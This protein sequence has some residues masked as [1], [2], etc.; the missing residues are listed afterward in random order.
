MREE[1]LQRLLAEVVRWVVIPADIADR[2]AS[3]LRE[4]QRDKEREHRAALMRLQQRHLAV[5]AKL[6][7][8]Y[9]DRPRP[10]G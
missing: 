1:D 9:E 3:A 10:S 6:D 4:S 8:A 5:Q 7:R 2:L